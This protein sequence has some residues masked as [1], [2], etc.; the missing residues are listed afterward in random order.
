M[1]CHEPTRRTMRGVDTPI[2]S[3]GEVIDMTMALGKLTNPAITCV[4]L[5]VNTEHL[6]EDAA[7]TVLDRLAREY[8]LPATDPVRFGV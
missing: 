1:V 6:G 7:F 8:E 2:P 5:S 4:G 3:I